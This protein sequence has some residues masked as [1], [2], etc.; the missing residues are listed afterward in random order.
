MPKETAD[1]ITNRKFRGLRILVEGNVPIA[2]GLS[3]SSSFCVCSALL[4]L[5]ANGLEPWTHK[6]ELIERIIKYE[7]MVG[8]ACGGMDQSISVLGLKQACLYIQ[9]RPI[10]SETVVLPAGYKFV[11]M[12]SLE[13][14]KKL[15]TIG[16]RYNKR[17]CECTIAV[18]LLCK[19][20]QLP[21]EVYEGW[22]VLKEV[23]DHLKLSLANMSHVVDQFIEK[24]PYAKPELEMLLERPLEEVL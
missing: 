11:I 22:K 6:Q 18:R 4:S 23:Q 20:L 5:H 9:F 14:S 13:E 2:A 21:K 10:R 24:R 7:R 3:S 19:K 8:T 15:E 17:V 16:T 12:N 1:I